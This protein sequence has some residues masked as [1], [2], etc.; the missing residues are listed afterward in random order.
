[1]DEVVASWTRW[2][3]TSDK[4]GDECWIEYWDRKRRERH[5]ED[6]F[7]SLCEIERA[8]YPASHVLC[9]ASQPCQQ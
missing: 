4:R 9:A 6:C 5:G 7:C 2:P 8:G 3:D 1:M